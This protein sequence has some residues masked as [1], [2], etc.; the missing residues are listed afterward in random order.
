M[1]FPR[2]YEISCA[3][4]AHPLVPTRGSVMG[5][6]HLK[7]SISNRFLE[8]P[9]PDRNDKTIMSKNPVSHIARR[10]VATPGLDPKLLQ[11]QRY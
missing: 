2:Q 3:M 6:V 4:E 7:L 5:T 1:F 10:D 8:I 11:R 9:K